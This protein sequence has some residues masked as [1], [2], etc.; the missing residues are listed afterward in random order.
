MKAIYIVC[1]IALLGAMMVA[2]A[3]ATTWYVHDGE[4]IQAA[5]DSA[6]DGDT[7]FVYNG[8]YSG[9]DLIIDKP[10]I[11]IRGEGADVVTF[12]GMGSFWVSIGQSA[13]ASGC[14][15][16]GFKII[17]PGGPQ[18]IHVGGSNDV[19]SSNIIIRNNCI[20][21]P[22]N[23]AIVYFD[24]TGSNNAVI[25]NTIDGSAYYGS[26]VIYQASSG[27]VSTNY[28]IANN[29]ITNNN[30][31]AAILLYQTPASDVN[32]ITKNNISSNAKGVW[33]YEAGSDNKI[34]LNNFDGNTESVVYDGTP[35]ATIYWNSTEPIEYIYGGATYTNYLG[36]YW[37]SDYT[38]G[39]TSP[40]DGIG[41]VPYVVY[42]TDSDHRPLMTGFE[43]YLEVPA[44]ADPDL[45]PTSIANDSLS[46]GV[47]AAITVDVF[48]I[49]SA[50][51]GSF[52]VTLKVEET[53]IGSDTVALLG[54]GSSVPVVFTWTP[55][56]AGSFNLTAIVDSVDAVAESDEANNGLTKEVTVTP[57]AATTWDVYEGDSIQDALNSASDGDT[58]FV[59]AGAYSEEIAINKPNITLKGEGADVVILSGT[60]VGNN[61]AIGGCSGA[62]PGCI[63][64]GLTSTNCGCALVLFPNSPNCIF[65]N[66]VFDGG[67]D[68][69]GSV[70]LVDNTTFTNNVVVNTTGAYGAVCLHDCQFSK[71]VN[72][73]IR[74][75][76]GAGILIFSDAGTATNNII[77]GNNISS[78]G[79]G[80]FA[81]S[82][83]PGHRIYLNSFVDNGVTATTFG[84]AAP[85][86]T[87][88]NSTEP[89]TYTHGG[90]TYT[91]YLGNYWDSDYTGS[92]GDGDGLG[93]TSY[94]IPDGLGEDHRP[95]MTGFE[96]YLGEGAVDPNQT[97]NAN[98]VY[99]VPEDF[100]VQGYCNSTT[101]E[102]WV[103]TSFATIGGEFEFSYTVSC[104]NVTDFEGNPDLDD[105]NWFNSP[106]WS[107][108]GVDFEVEEAVGPG[109]LWVG[110]L[111]IRCC[112]ESSDCVTDLAWIPEQCVLYNAEDEIEI[113]NF[114]DGTFTCEPAEEPS[115]PTPPTSF[116]ISGNITYDNGNPVMNP[117]VTVTN[118]ATSEDF[119][120]KTDASSNYYL[121][122]T[123]STHVTAGDTIRINTSDGTVSNETDHPVTASEIEIGGFVQDMTIESGELPD[124]TVTEK[125]EE[126]INLA[127]GTYNVTCTVANIGTSGADASTTAI[128]IDGTVVTT[129]SVP[130][131]AI[132][133]SHTST[134]GP[135]TLSGENDTIRVCADSDD[136]IIELDETNNCLENVLEAPGMPDLI[137]WVALKTPGYVN[138][139]NILGVRVKNTGI[140]DAGS[141]NVS[142]AI[143]GT[144]VP[145]QTVPALAGGD[146]TELEYTWMPTE[147]GGHLLSATADT[148]NDVEESDE[149]NNDYARTSII[150][151]S[152][153]WPQFNYDAS[154][155]GFSPSGAPSSNCVKWISED[156]GA[157]GGLS[158]GGTSDM[159]PVV[160]NGKIFTYCGAG[161][162]SAETYDVAC[163]DEETGELLW[164]ITLP[165]Q[166]AYGS[167]APLGYDDGM[168]FCTLNH[169][170]V[171][172]DA[173]DGSIVWECD[174]DSPEFEGHAWSVNS[175]PTIA[176]G[177][178]FTGT[179]D[180]GGIGGAGGLAGYVAI[181]EYTGEKLWQTTGDGHCDSTPAYYDGV[182][183]VGFD[184]DWTASPSGGCYAI[185]VSTGEEEW[186]TWLPFSIW[187]SVSVDED[188]V[189]GA[190]Y[191]FY[192]SAQVFILYRNNGTV[193][194]ISESL[195]TDSTPA[196]AYD[197][198]YICGGCTGYSDTGT[199]C[200]DKETL[201]VIWNASAGSWTASPAVA[202]G[203]VYV[204]G[205]CYDAFTG[206]E[207]FSYEQ[208][209]LSPVIA[210]GYLFNVQNGSVVCFEDIL[211]NIP[212]LNVTEIVTPERLRADVINPISATVEN[213]G[214]SDAGSFDISF[215][216][217]GIPVDTASVTSLAA[218]ENTTVEFLWTPSS[219]GNQTLIVTADVSEAVTESDETNNNR[220]E[221]AEVLEKLTVTASVRIEGMN[222]TIWCGDVTFSNSTITTSNGSVHYLNEPTALGALDEA[223]KSGEFGYVVESHTVYGLYVSEVNNE[224]AI[225][226]DGWM[227]RV[228]YI[229]PW[230]GAADYTLADSDDVLW[231]F[232]AWT[233]PPLAIELN[234][235]AVDTGEEFAATVTAYNS[236]S[237]A[238]EPVD[239]AEIYVDDVLHGLTGTDGTLTISLGVPGI[240][241][242]HADK[243]TW[244][245]YTR[246]GKESVNVATF[247]LK[248]DIGD[249]VVTEGSSI[250]API[251]VYGIE[252]Y[253][254]TTLSIEYDSSVAWV[255]SVDGTANSTISSSNTN[256]PAGI[257]T[258]SAWNTDGVSGDV[259]IAYVTFEARGSSGSSA[260]LN[261]SVLLMKDTSYNNV[262]TR[263]EDGLFTVREDVMPVVGSPQSSPDT[264]LNDNG[265]ARVPGTN[266]STLSVS[267]TDN[268]GIA[269]VTIDLSPIGGNAT[270]PMT[271]SGGT[272]WSVVVNA[273]AGINE[274]HYLGVNA[275]DTSGNSNTG[276]SVSLGVLRR[277][278]VVRDNEVD[279]LD[280]YYIARYSVGLEPAPDQFVSDVSPAD[281]WDGVDIVD[282]FYIARYDVGLEDAP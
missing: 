13:T 276:V 264:I 72:N 96:N 60:G 140:V 85:A 49:G 134:L 34:Y 169:Y 26:I 180:E 248:V 122:L 12:D 116:L 102:V 65:R 14:I 54:A 132:G 135:F 232:G 78:N 91:D 241:Q 48:N 98:A 138:E 269:S 195:R 211:E 206:E 142:L 22:T 92:D 219:T 62:A 168:V 271:P 165:Y 39:D 31:G 10:N 86:V 126:W 57:A 259:V 4:S 40:E 109:P 260:P 30:N 246:S 61:I 125:S 188:Y 202:D 37:G 43:N 41:D 210:N 177:K 240:Y 5:V 278:D 73:I 119:I 32:T 244:A 35:P 79:Y 197:N 118:L 198:I 249:Y 153:D 212:D 45:T 21:G 108:A 224:P 3:A 258:L 189:Y 214:G 50:E 247:A 106:E 234:K 171:A 152:T 191:N 173:D 257:V 51:A 203:K 141:F 204:G 36:N 186:R 105:T 185:N 88:W 216:V 170:V 273:T 242:I 262:P 7:V 254:T 160:A 205:Y 100:T 268:A 231:Y 20:I 238:F 208:G 145:E 164:N 150:I 230:V 217:D 149:T 243:G 220:S 251:T 104:A 274:N 103:N 159:G 46:A 89:I 56:A 163:L 184:H 272:I 256:N 33:L 235:T 9:Y 87:Y 124:L 190:N 97:Y 131:L 263:D 192:G 282:A 6:S 52:N 66:N 225:L 75:N 172:L 266:L 227:Y 137:I 101:V 47:P 130:A 94:V 70:I 67:S 275:T 136:N 201:E 175:G 55:D 113:E 250:V 279:I 176:D 228:N 127:D 82:A 25:N 44:A 117:V 81:Y 277:G 261:L 209:G 157:G 53:V 237:M 114:G 107:S 111:T 178:V 166:M 187:G 182:I 93:D 253:G 280:A 148:N 199:F 151:N 146:T 200:V 59:H 156:I 236:T 63:I 29:T 154:G 174:L 143:D 194:V 68:D 161:G 83:G 99:F 18:A 58:I 183:Y 270:Q 155:I 84:S 80:I 193:K 27:I 69:G 158:W 77:S 229:S 123:D 221:I 215:A 71:V 223:D 76:V 15:F 2:P 181:D 255:T 120:V 196:V 8:T 245:N 42:G 265:R 162:V 11:T 252:D 112:N 23:T 24:R 17:N 64:E 281:Q 90:S 179:Y 38:G 133:E 222:D 207:I 1:V 28:L 139:E 74:D 267:A 147:F 218:A 128:E 19:E 239:G 115:T 233:A 95:L 213:I 121:T 167:W 16:E 226:W 129:D 110:N 144:Q